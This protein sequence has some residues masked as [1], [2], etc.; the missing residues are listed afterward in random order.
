MKH[1]LAAEVEKYQEQHG[2]A[3][4]TREDVIMLKILEAKLEHES[5]IGSES[6]LRTSKA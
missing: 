6:G 3:G 1:I 4:M 5:R 2:H